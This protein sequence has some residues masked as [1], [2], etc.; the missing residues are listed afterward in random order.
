MFSGQVVGR[1][2]AGRHRRVQVLAGGPVDARA[3]Y[4]RAVD[5]IAPGGETVWCKSVAYLVEQHLP[6]RGALDHRP[7]EHLGQLPQLAAAPVS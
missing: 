5:L 6:E 7:P 4:P 1:R 2:P 3:D